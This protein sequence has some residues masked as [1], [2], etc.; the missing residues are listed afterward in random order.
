MKSRTSYKSIIV[1]IILAVITMA[2]IASI[3]LSINNQTYL[4]EY[5]LETNAIVIELRREYGTTLLFP[6]TRVYVNYMAG[7]MLYR[8]NLRINPRDTHVGEI[9][10][11]YYSANNPGLITV[12]DRGRATD[13]PWRLTWIL[14][15]WLVYVSIMWYTRHRESKKKIGK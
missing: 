15:V 2:V 6:T 9:I 4:R 8:R 14:A 13:T 12:A 10:P 5:G 11:I 1:A 3:F 7:N